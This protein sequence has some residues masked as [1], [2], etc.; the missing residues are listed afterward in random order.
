M[1]STVHSVKVI[2]NAHS[3]FGQSSR[4]DLLL[5]RDFNMISINF[6]S[7]F[8]FFFFFFWRLGCALFQAPRENNGKEKK[9]NRELEKD[10]LQ[11]TLPYRESGMKSSQKEAEGKEEKSNGF[12]FLLFFLFFFTTYFLLFFFPPPPPPFF[13]DFT[14]L[15]G[16]GGGGLGFLVDTLGFLGAILGSLGAILAV[17]GC[18]RRLHSLRRSSP[19]SRPCRCVRSSP[20]AFSGVFSPPRLLEYFCLRA[21]SERFCFGLRRLRLT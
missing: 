15:A 2:S 11:W 6:P 19:D 8:F 21:V 12:F 13:F 4:Q 9:R 1:I 20:P 10:S 5:F 18:R 14:C 7:F 16:L 3:N 17:L